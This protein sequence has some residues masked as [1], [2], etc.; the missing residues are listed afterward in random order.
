VW[1][2]ITND[3]T[4][5]RYL[6]GA[7]FDIESIQ[8][9]ADGFWIGEEFGPFLFKVDTAGKVVSVHDTIVDGKAVKSPD[10]PTL[11]VPANPTLPM[12]AFNLKRSGGFEGLALSKDGT[13]LYGMLEGALY[14]EDGT[15][16]MVDGARVFRVVEFDTAN[17]A[18]TGR[19]WLYP[20]AEGGDAIGDFNMVDATTA[21][22]IER[23]KGAGNGGHRPAPTRKAPTA[24]LLRQPGETQARLQDRDERGQCR[25]RG[26]QGRL[27]RPDEDPVTPT[28]SPARAGSTASTTCRSSPSRTSTSSMRRTSSSA[29]TTTCR[30]RRAGRSTRPTTTS[31][32]CSRSATS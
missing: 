17:G 10:H 13:K 21:L 8:P 7:D 29:T 5:E 3:G 24:G 2:P 11:A 4:A 16:E 18:V 31:S 27:H 19:T 15:M 32:S 22:V 12:P 25:R 14:L 20:L 6:T 23:D 9:V 30:S 26:D 28:A 1:F